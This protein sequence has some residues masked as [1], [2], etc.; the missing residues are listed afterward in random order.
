[1][2]RLLLGAYYFLYTLS[3]VILMLLMM[4]MN[5]WVN[6]GIAIGA[7]I[8]KIF[9]ITKYFKDFSFS[10]AKMQ[11]NKMEIQTNVPDAIDK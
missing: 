10:K 6:I 9:K 8:G 4:T 11:S 7:G 1:M 2:V 3:N 5:G